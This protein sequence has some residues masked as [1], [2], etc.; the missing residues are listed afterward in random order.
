[1]RVVSIVSGVA[2]QVPQDET[3][4]SVICPERYMVARACQRTQ[5]R[6]S[7]ATR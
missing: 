7:K 4:G 1:M 2:G 3:G 5:E 6:E